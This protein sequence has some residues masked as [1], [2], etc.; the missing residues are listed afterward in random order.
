VP[1]SEKQ[2]FSIL[3]HWLATLGLRSS[4]YFS[5]KWDNN[6]RHTSDLDAALPCLFYEYWVLLTETWN[7]SD[8]H[9]QHT[10]SRWFS[11]SY[12]EFWQLFPVLSLAFASYFLTDVVELAFFSITLSFA[13]FYEGFSPSM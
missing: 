7:L 1:F 6:D 11:A 2:I 10:C 5:G 13:I 9:T 3:L 4:A 8:S 12:S